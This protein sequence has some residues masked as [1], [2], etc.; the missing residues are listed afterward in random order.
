MTTAADKPL[1]N[2][3]GWKVHQSEFV[4]T[5]PWFSVR[6]DQVSF[7]NGRSG[8]YSYLEHPGSAF[9]VPILQDGRVVLMRSYR[10]TLDAFCWEI[11]AGRI[12]LGQ[13]PEQCARA[14]LQEEIGAHTDSIEHLTT[15]HIANGFARCPCYFYLATNVILDCNTS[16]EDGETIT[17]IEAVSFDEAMIRLTKPSP[18]NKDQGDADSALALLLAAQRLREFQP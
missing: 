6:S 11:P 17:N 13:T 4:Y 10:Y 14:E 18:A 15:L 7:P 12:E 8:T 1:G 3:L 9:V 16:H 5:S 2:K